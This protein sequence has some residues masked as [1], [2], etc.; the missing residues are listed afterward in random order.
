MSPVGF[1]SII[2]STG[3]GS[4][5]GPEVDL[6]AGLSLDVLQPL[7]ENPD[8]V[9]KMKVLLPEVPGEDSSQLDHAQEIKS[10]IQSPQVSL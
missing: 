4:S 10:T 1:L 5:S 9:Q 3:L 6:A 2:Y 8:F 7:L